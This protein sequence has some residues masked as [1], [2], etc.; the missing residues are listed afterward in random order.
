MIPRP[1]DTRGAF[2]RQKLIPLRKQALTILSVQNER[3]E[4]MPDKSA[5]PAR[6][7]TLAD[8]AMGGWE[9]HTHDEKLDRASL[10]PTKTFSETV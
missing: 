5:A 1:A 2:F 4:K 9:G 7:N 10:N 6:V 3:V 8:T